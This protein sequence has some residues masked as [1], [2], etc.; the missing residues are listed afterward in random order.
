MIMSM[1]RLK[2]RI[3]HKTDQKYFSELEIKETLKV[4]EIFNPN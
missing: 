2:K 1:K 3:S 4:G